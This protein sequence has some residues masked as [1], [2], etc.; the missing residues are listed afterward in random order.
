MPLFASNK[1]QTEN[2]DGSIKRTFQ[3]IERA[4]RTTWHGF[5]NTLFAAFWSD[6]GGPHQVC[7]WEQD[8][9]GLVHLRGVAKLAGN[10]GIGATATIATLPINPPVSPVPSFVELFL[11]WGGTAYVQVI[12]NPNGTIQV[13]NISGALLT[14]PAVSLAGITYAT[15]PN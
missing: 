5:A 7:Q 11:Q 1:A 3:Q 4:T 12:V 6:F 10:I 13:Q 14:N 2:V 9:N 15:V 8:F